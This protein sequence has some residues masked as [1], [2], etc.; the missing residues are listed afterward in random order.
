[1]KDRDPA[2][3]I[4]LDPEIAEEVIPPQ[5]THQH[6]AKTRAKLNASS[7]YR[8]YKRLVRLVVTARARAGIHRA[9]L[10]GLEIEAKK[11]GP[12]FRETRGVG[13]A[14]RDR[15]QRK[16]LVAVERMKRN[17]DRRLYRTSRNDRCIRER[18]L[19]RRSS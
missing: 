10:A 6:W 13:P 5:K 2:P 19:A 7:G 8:P 18:L 17:R 11:L 15:I 3:L 16:G 12:I 4:E 9:L 1:M 14:V